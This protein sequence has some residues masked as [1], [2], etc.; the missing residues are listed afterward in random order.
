MHEGRS[1][2]IGPAGRRHHR[3]KRVVRAGG[4]GG[5]DTRP[6]FNLVGVRRKVA[7]FRGEVGG[8]SFL[9]RVGLGEA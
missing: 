2:G 3:L 5:G 1:E 4:S 9:Q 8:V 6:P 7:S